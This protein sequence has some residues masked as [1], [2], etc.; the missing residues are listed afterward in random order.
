[1]KKMEK[2]RPI[3]LGGTGSDVGKSVLAAGFCRIFRQDG[4][5]PAPFKAQN[6]ALNSFV[7]PDGLE[8]GRAQAAQAAAAGIECLVEMNPVLLKPSGEM[9]SQVVVNGRPEGNRSAYGYFREDDKSRLRQIAHEAFDRLSARFNPIVMEGAGSI[10]ELNLKHRDIVNMSMAEYADA[11]VILVADIDRGGVF[12]SVYGSVMLQDEKDRKRIAGVIVNKFRGDLRLFAEGRRIIEKTAGIP[13]LGVMPYLTDIHIEEE[14]SVSLKKKNTT[15]TTENLVNIAV[16]AVP[17]LS[18]FTDFDSLSIDSRV[19]LYFTMDP[20]EIRKAEIVILP[21]SKNTIGDLEIVGST[22]CRE[23]ISDCARRGISVF[24]ICGGYQMMGESVADPAGVE[25]SPRSIEGLGLLPVKT[26]LSGEKK[27]TRTDF[28]LPGSQTVNK[29][30]EIHVGVTE[31]IDPDSKEFAVT[32][33]GVKDGCRVSDRIM[34]TYLHGCLDNREVIDLLVAPYAKKRGL[35]AEIGRTHDEY[36]ELQYD[37]LAAE[38]RKYIDIDRI[39]DIMR[40]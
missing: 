36:M 37:R 21:G 15:S 4:Y 28:F 23:A 5:H 34:G 20:E 26:V 29:G 22:G 32:S 30:Y 38:M 8:I 16:V 6:M 17:H 10:A 33:G 11:R 18:N 12:A 13:V 3:M 39:Y 25:G 14:D 27:V 2:L 9:M 31:Q 1:M 24:G 35:R 40:R 7:T 19:H